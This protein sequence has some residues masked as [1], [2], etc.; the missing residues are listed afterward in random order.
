MDAILV[1]EPVEHSDISGAIVSND[2]G[3]STPAAENVFK[4]KSADGSACFSSE[5]TSFGPGQEGTAGLDDIAEARS[6]GHEHGVNIN[7][8]KEG[9]RKVDN[10]RD[11]N[12][13]G[14]MKLAFMTSVNI[15]FY[16]LL[17]RRPPEAIK[18]CAVSQV[19]AFVAQ[20]VVGITNEGEALRRGDI[21]L[22]SALSSKMPELVVD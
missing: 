16:I 15:P 13:G 7:L 21:E 6:K 14:L 18:E 17:Q 5:C 11:V 2:F 20:V 8:V 22:V 19:K 10:R 12:L 1:S 4:D 9:S 3:N